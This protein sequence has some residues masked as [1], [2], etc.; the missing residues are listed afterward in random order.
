MILFA[1][2]PILLALGL[3]AIFTRR[4]VVA[5]LVSAAL[6]AGLLLVLK[7]AQLIGTTLPSIA[8]ISALA[9]VPAILAAHLGAR[10]RLIFSKEA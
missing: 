2:A 6:F 9:A 3:G 7:S 5:G 8:I 10:L 1:G 4:P